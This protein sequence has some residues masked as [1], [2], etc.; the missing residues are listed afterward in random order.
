VKVAVVTIVSGRHDHVERQHAGLPEDV[1]YI[2]VAMNDP[3]LL[4]WRPTEPTATVI[5][6][7]SDDRLPVAAARNL[8]A[9]RA[10]ER[11]AELLVFLDVDCIPLPGLIAGYAAAATDDRL[12]TGAV[13]YLPEGSLDP[14]DAHFHGFR[15]RPVEGEIVAGESRLF[16]SLSFASTLA[17]WTRI[18]GFDEAFLGYGGEDTDFALRAESDG[19]DVVWVGGAEAVHQYH[20]TNSPPVQHLDDILRNGA[21]FSKRWGFWPMQGWLDAFVEMG[22]VERND[23]TGAYSATS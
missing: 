19:L 2:V 23:V 7:T 13:G 9:T 8:G 11:G 12:L 16:W 20:P 21:I 15:P 22:L 4:E 1:D 17:V 14:Q 18:G 3:A 10:I 6:I 5:P